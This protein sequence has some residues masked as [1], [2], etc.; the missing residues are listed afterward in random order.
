MAFWRDLT[1]EDIA[2]FDFSSGDNDAVFVEIGFG[3]FP[4]VWNITRDF[5]GAEFC[6]TALEIVGFNVNRS[7]DIFLHHAFRHDD[8]VFVVITMPRHVG[9]KH[10]LTK[11]KFTIAHSRTISDDLSFFDFVANFNDWSLVNASALVRTVELLETINVFFASFF[12]FD[13]SAIHIGNS[14]IGASN[15]GKTAIASNLPF[16]TRSNIGERWAEKRKSLTLHVR[17][18]QS[19]GSIVVFKEWNTSSRH[20]DDFFWRNVDIR[21]FIHW[22]KTAIIIVTSNDFWIEEFFDN[23]LMAV[24]KSHFFWRA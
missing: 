2:F 5:F 3:V 16:H 10:V 17:A 1:N 13:G 9:D 15:H 19:T 20:R 4:N 21:N 18:H 6:F 23:F 22:D 7:V 8:G 11:G 12:D 24:G 14:T